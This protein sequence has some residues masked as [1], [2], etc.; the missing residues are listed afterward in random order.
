VDDAT[1][2][3]AAADETARREQTMSILS[4]LCRPVRSTRLA[5]RAARSPLR[6]MHWRRSLK[7]AKRLWFDYGHLRS[8]CTESAVDRD[9]HP[10]PWYTYPAIEFLAQLD[11][12]RCRVFEYG[13]GNS[14]LFWAQRAREVVSVE[15]DRQWYEYVRARV[16]ANAT[17]IYEPD[18]QEYAAAIGRVAGGFD[19]IVVDGPARRLT[20]ARGAAAALTRL[21]PGGLIILDNSDWLPR[22]ASLLRD[23]DLLQVDFSGFVPIG[24]ST[25]TT[26]LYFHREFRLRP[27]GERQ[28]RLSIGAAAKDW[29]SHH[30]VSASEIRASVAE[31]AEMAEAAEN[32]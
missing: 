5:E 20:R 10:L 22:S 29:E 27:V 9:G 8:V 28:P 21:N 7:A 23:T 30:A 1:S 14:T 32:S 18:L 6:P 4:T 16:P 31:M 26:S 19:V 11:F 15:H 17:V 25:Q 24:S 3:I 2:S 13:T 12:S